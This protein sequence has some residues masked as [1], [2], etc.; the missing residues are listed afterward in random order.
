MLLRGWGIRNDEFGI[1]GWEL[2][3]EIDKA[4]II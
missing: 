3:F 2:E 4:W 1:C